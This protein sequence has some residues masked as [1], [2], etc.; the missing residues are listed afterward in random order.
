MGF[1]LGLQ[2]LGK[3]V[4]GLLGDEGSGFGVVG[5]EEQGLG[6]GGVTRFRRVGNPMSVAET[7]ATAHLCPW[8]EG[9]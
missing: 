6:H 9:I 5:V 3:G 4:K 8:G 7:Y 1:G 2:A